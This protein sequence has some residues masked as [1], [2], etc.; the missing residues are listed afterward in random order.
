MN[1]FNKI[2]VMIVGSGMFVTG[3]GTDNYGTILPAV[4]NANLNGLVSEISVVSTSTKSS[5]FVNKC[6]NQ[7]S[8]IFKSKFNIKIFPKIKNNKK[9]YLKVAKDLKPD[10]AIISVPDNLHYEI[11]KNLIKLKIHCLV[12][13][14]LCDNKRDAKH[15]IKLIHSPYSPYCGAIQYGTMVPDPKWI[16]N[17]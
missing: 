7:L 15:L 9:E 12:V 4:C 3:R 5:K 14:P 17:P 8:K 13:K 2:K 16:T 6:N 1:K 10:A 11:C